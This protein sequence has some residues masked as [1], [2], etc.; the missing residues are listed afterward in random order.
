MADDVLEFWPDD[1]Q[2]PLW[3]GGRP[4]DLYALGLPARLVHRLESWN[5][6]YRED[7]LPI[8]GRG[9]PDY[10]ATG[11]ALLRDVTE[12]LGDRY[13]IIVNEPWWNATPAP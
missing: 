10:V 4:A 12:A 3:S 6:E 9:D 8:D 7:R 13:R 11:T 5:A 1:K 2:G